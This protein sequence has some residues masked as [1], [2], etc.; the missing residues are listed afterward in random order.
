MFLAYMML[1]H[2]HQHLSLFHQWF[3]LNFLPSNLYL[4]SHDICFT[5]VFDSL[6]PVIKLN[7]LRFNFSVLFGTHTLLLKSLKVLQ[8]PTHLSN[9]TGMESS[10]VLDCIH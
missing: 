5:N 1:L 8:F 9:L 6:I 4:H 10:V 2:S 7:M 3:E